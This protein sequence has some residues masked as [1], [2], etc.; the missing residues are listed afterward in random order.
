MRAL[1]GGVIMNLALGLPD[2]PLLLID[3]LKDRLKPF[4]CTVRQVDFDVQVYCEGSLQ[5]CAEVIAIVQD[6]NFRPKEY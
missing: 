6:Y 1:F 2:F 5:T 4:N 3:E